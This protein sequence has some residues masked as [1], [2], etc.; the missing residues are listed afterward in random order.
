[1]SVGV[2]TRTGRPDAE[3]LKA[4]PAPDAVPREG[5]DDTRP[6]PAKRRRW[7]PVIGVLLLA[8]LGYGLWRVFAP[9][10]PSGRRGGQEAQR[11]GAAKIGVGDIRE[12]FSGLGT[13]TPLATITVQTQINGQLQ[14]VGFK[15]GQLVQKGDFLAQIDDRPYQAALHQAEGALAHDTGLLKQAESDLQRYETL[16]RQDS[17]A[18]QQVVDQQFLVE[19]DKGT[20]AEDHATIETD[21]LNITYCHIV[22]PVT[23]RVGLR[24]VDPGNYV[25]TT[26]TT[27]LVVLTQ[28]QPISVVFVLPED[29]IQDLWPQVKD[30]KTLS[31]T[32]YD[33]SNAKLLATGSLESV[34][35][36]I[37]TTTGT[38]KL[39]ANFPNTD[40]A[41]FP[42]QFVNAR[43]LV[44]T[45]P[46]VTT[47]P[48][49]A[50]QHGAPG[51]FVYLIKSDNTVT[52]R[53]VTTGVTDV[54]S[55]QIMSGLQPGDNVVVDG[56]DRLRE[57]AK[58]E[59]VSDKADPA[60]NVD[61][62]AKARAG[63]SGGDSS[64][65]HHGKPEA[66]NG[67][68][69]ESNAAHSGQP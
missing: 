19:Q 15:E 16:G 34:D 17:I 68:N 47:A 61:G 31:V 41:L 2:E 6:A 12:I 55:I 36:E 63:E 38:L 37:D 4:L 66:K 65:Q 25:Q 29:Q 8:L 43:L 49:A 9:S 69:S 51:A 58:V 1:V 10:A 7:R 27:G 53:T 42:N 44:R 18:L 48:T 56:A 52:A 21:K 5:Q 40:E 54:D 28:L 50:I 26:S 46:K 3:A 57:G 60:A 30:G 11:V 35:N 64:R 59:I 32:A 24:L 67:A 39:R 33:R 23:G 13:V 22:A 62:D 45:L 14:S 20:V